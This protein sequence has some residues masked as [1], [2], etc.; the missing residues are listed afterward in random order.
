MYFRGTD[1]A[2]TAILAVNPD[3][4]PGEREVSGGSKF[5][6]RQRLVLARNV[7]EPQA[8][9]LASQPDRR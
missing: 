1:E 4:A 6:Q 7:P 2:A 5:D 3:D 8:A 9:S